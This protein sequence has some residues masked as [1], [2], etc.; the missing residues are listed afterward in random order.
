[1]KNACSTGRLFGGL[2]FTSLVLTPR[3]ASADFGMGVAASLNVAFKDGLS[4]GWGLEVR[5]GWSLNTVYCADE[6]TRYGVGPSLQYARGHGQSGRLTLAA[7][8]GWEVDRYFLTGLSEVGM[9][10]PTDSREPAL[11][12]GLKA[13]STLAQV[14]VRGN[15][16]LWT[17]GIGPELGGASGYYGAF[18][19]D[20]V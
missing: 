10:F 3:D 15:S 16:D 6:G 4:L 17:V 9:M 1:M 8:A 19:C 14:A 13:Q 11:H 7:Q 2:L 20:S 5:G 18:F 12:L